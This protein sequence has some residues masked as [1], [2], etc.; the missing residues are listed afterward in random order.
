MP[1]GYIGE[2]YSLN[3]TTVEFTVVS[4]RAALEKFQEGSSLSDVPCT[5]GQ[6]AVWK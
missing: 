1:D 5:T 2:G 4:D 6:A 3:D